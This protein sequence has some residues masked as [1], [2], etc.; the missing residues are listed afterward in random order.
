MSMVTLCAAGSARSVTS[1][2]MI[3]AMILIVCIIFLSA[4]TGIAM[5]AAEVLR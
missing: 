4:F 1:G 5:L 3:T 2:Q